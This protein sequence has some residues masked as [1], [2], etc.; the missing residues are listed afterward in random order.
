VGR[1]QENLKNLESVG[2]GPSSLAGRRCEG[3]AFSPKPLVFEPIFVQ[4]GIDRRKRGLH[5]GL[6]SQKR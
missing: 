3:W 2:W 4:G 5:I 6:A 1:P